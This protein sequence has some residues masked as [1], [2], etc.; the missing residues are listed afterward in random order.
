MW[1]VT[2][3]SCCKSV[4]FHSL[5]STMAVCAYCRTVVDRRKQNSRGSPKMAA[6]AKGAGPRLMGRTGYFEGRAFSVVGQRQW[7]AGQRVWNQWWLLMRDD[8]LEWRLLEAEGHYAIVSREQLGQALPRFEQLKPRLRLKLFDRTWVVSG[9]RDVRSSGGEGEWA[10]PQAARQRARMVDLEAGDGVLMLD[11]SGGNTPVPYLGKRVALEALISLP[12]PAAKQAQVPADGPATSPSSEDLDLGPMG[13]AHMVVVCYLVMTLIFFCI[14]GFTWHMGQTWV[15][16]LTLAGVYLP[17]RLL[18]KMAD[19]EQG[20]SMLG[21]YVLYA[22]IVMGVA[23]F[24]QM[25]QEED[26]GYSASS[27]STWGG[28]AGHK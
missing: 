1:I 23:L 14:S 7:R 8:L 21:G 13:W 18:E 6:L 5:A 28:S 9:V 24:Y 26:D 27:G 10:M 15:F 2:C 22:F 17:A 12:E 25:I 20:H 11:Y 3:P 19:K 16:L 4:K